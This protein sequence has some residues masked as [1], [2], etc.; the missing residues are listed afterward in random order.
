M[1]NA[2]K[3]AAWIGMLIGLVIILL[4]GG[5]WRTELTFTPGSNSVGTQVP[6]EENLTANHFLG[7]LVQGGQPDLNQV[8]AKHVGQG[9]QVTGL[10]IIT[11]H[12]LVNCLLTGVTL[13]I[14]SPVTVTIRGKV[15]RSAA[16]AAQ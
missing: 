9:E 4:A 1:D 14:Y 3:T 5:V 15:G 16:P 6:F 8:L 12:T 10:T 7:G 11:R 13:F 2:T